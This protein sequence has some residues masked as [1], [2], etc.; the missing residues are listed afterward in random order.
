[1]NH[2]IYIFSLIIIL[3]GCVG[4]NDS[5]KESKV[6]NYINVKDNA[7]QLS[8]N[9][10]VNISFDKAPEKISFDSFASEVKIM[11]LK[12]TEDILIGKITDISSVNEKFYITDARK[13]T[14][15]CFDITGEFKFQIKAQGKGVKEI[16][17]I[18]NVFL[19]PDE[20]ILSIFDLFL[21]RLNIYSADSGKFI[22]QTKFR[23]NL[24]LGNLIPFSE[25]KYLTTF[26]NLYTG[27]EEESFNLFILEGNKVVSRNLPFKNQWN[28]FYTGI[29]GVSVF[30]KKLTYYSTPDQAAY[31]ID[32]KSSTIRKKYTFNYGKRDVSIFL[33]EYNQVKDITPSHP[34]YN[35]KRDPLYTELLSHDI[36]SGVET[37]FE[38]KNHIWASFK[39]KKGKVQAIYNKNKK[40]SLLADHLVCSNPLHS[41]MFKSNILGTY[42]DSFFIAVVYP[43]DF[44]LEM[45]DY[46]KAIG[47]DRYQEFLKNNPVEKGLLKSFKEEDN[48]MLMLIKLRD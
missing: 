8:S 26:N 14:L 16:S 10:A 1:M 42:N 7:L 44:L 24:S 43:N 36:Y 34:K 12:T 13:K 41:V 9:K 4:K 28:N 27:N 30:N 11:P 38:T 5:K 31:E 23:T 29:D 37:Y 3:A 45:D 39:H 47:I 33:K 17:K 20:N 2:L 46:E 6:Q 40:T 35:Q 22:S 25:G 15:F 32:T 18:G 48:P 21:G 19:T